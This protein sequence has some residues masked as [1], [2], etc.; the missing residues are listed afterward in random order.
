MKV[1][2]DFNIPL[3]NMRDKNVGAMLNIEAEVFNPG[4]PSAF[5]TINKVS[6]GGMEILWN[7]TGSPE[8]MAT[9]CGIAIDHAN[10]QLNRLD[11][12]I[13]SIYTKR[14]EEVLV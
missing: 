7:L 8:L 11:A 1:T 2:F 14:E 3:E 4:L 6:G 10:D 5:A 13:T 12:E 9:V